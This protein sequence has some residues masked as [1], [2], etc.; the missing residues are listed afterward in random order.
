MVQVSVCC[1]DLAWSE[2]TSGIVHST[3]YTHSEGPWRRTK[4]S[5][6]ATTALKP[7][8]T[9]AINVIEHTT[10]NEIQCLAKHECPILG[11]L[12]C[13]GSSRERSPTS[14][15]HFNAAYYLGELQS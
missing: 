5:K 7:A 15:V 8:P 11:S 2:T 6:P 13:S 3:I 1:V 14:I 9:M 10:V 4:S 12:S